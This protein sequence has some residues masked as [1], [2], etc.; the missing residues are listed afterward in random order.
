M[1]KPRDKGIK[2]FARSKVPASHLFLDLANSSVY[3][4]FKSALEEGLSLFKFKVGFDVDYI[5]NFSF[6]KKFKKSLLKKNSKYV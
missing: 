2:S 6:Q 4:K 5:R 1:L 3:S